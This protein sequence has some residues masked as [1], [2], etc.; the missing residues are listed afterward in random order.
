M[1][2]QELTRREFLKKAMM[3]AGAL[4]SCTS[5]AR[6]LEAISETGSENSSTEKSNRPISIYDSLISKYSKKQGFDEDLI[7]AQIK[8]E[9]NFNPR[10]VSSEGARGL[11]QVMPGTAK[12][13]GYRPE[14]MFEPEKSIEA[15]TRY[16]RQM[17]EKPNMQGREEWESVYLALASYNA[18]YGNIARAIGA[19]N[20]ANRGKRTYT[21]YI[22]SKRTR[23]VQVAHLKGTPETWAGYSKALPLITGK[24]ATETIGYVEKVKKNFLEYKKARQ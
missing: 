17:Y 3:G 23:T 13:L 8:Q 21:Y 12:D 22:T 20:S 19:I 15:G 10:A 16:M 9:S 4:V 18:G 24:R 6:G 1:E 2:K 5:I 7:R 14:E 11:M